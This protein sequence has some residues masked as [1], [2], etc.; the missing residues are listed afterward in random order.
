MVPFQ[1]YSGVCIVMDDETASSLAQVSRH[2]Q[3]CKVYSGVI[4]EMCSCSAVE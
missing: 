4:L 2:E 3:P 1:V